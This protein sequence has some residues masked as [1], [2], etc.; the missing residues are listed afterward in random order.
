[1]YAV[2]FDIDGTLLHTGGAGSQAF[3]ETFDEL[4][5]VSEISSAVGF[6]GRS[7]R[8]IAE[9]LMRVHEIDPSPENWQR[10]AAGYCARLGGVL[11]RCKGHVLPGVLE[12]L[13]GLEKMEHV[14]VGLLTGNIREGA[15]AKLSHYGLF[16]RFAF[17]G[18]GDHRTDRN[19]I[20]V[21]ALQATH[22]YMQRSANGQGYDIA[23]VMVIG[24]TPADIAC[25][26]AID[27]CAVGTATG[28]ADYNTLSATN[29]DLLLPNL[30]DPTEILAIID[31][32]STSFQR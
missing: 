8:A 20:A 4:F 25:A 6:A 19:D 27:A 5:G 31:V 28:G 10:F 32:A 17:G 23:G 11:A 7:D 30:S 9:E 3:A 1:M 24:D 22:E 12:L 14:A 13:D 15:R 21:D 26:R 2:L 18:F 29:P 16:E